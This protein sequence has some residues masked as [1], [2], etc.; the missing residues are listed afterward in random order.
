MGAFGY[1]TSKEKTSYVSANNPSFNFSEKKA[2]GNGFEVV[3][4]EDAY[5]GRYFMKEGK[6]WIHNITALKGQLNINNDYQ[7]TR[8]GYDVDAFYAC[9]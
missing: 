8:M 3:Y 1:A 7:L 9:H 5:N 2:L 4:D 6:K